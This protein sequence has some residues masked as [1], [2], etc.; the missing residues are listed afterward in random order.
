MSTKSGRTFVHDLQLI[1]CNTYPFSFSKI[2]RGFSAFKENTGQTHPNDIGNTPPAKRTTKRATGT[3]PLTDDLDGD[4]WQGGV[5][6]GTPLSAF[7]GGRLP[8]HLEIV[9]D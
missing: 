2:A 7:T 1:L 5:S 6:V 3:D 8:F 4:L 9:T